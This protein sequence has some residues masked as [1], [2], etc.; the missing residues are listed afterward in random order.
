M[1]TPLVSILLPA[2]QSERYIGETIESAL[3]QTFTDWELVISEN[4]SKDK[5]L[6]VIKKY[7]D[8]RIRLFCQEKTTSSAMNWQFVFEHALGEF[9]CV[10]GADDVFEAN[11][12]E[13]KLSL[14][15]QFPNSPFVHGAVHCID[16]NGAKTKVYKQEVPLEEAPA[17]FL[18]R[19]FPANLVNA[20]SALFRLRDA[21]AKKIGFDTRYTLLM[22]WCF[23]MEFALNT[24]GTILYDDL[25]TMKYRMH[26]QNTTSQQ[27]KGFVW[28][29]ESIELRL[30]LL[31]R[32]ADRW[33]E[34]GTDPEMEK[35]RIT[36]NLWALAFQQVRRG[37]W[38]GGARAWKDYREYHSVRA[39]FCDA[40]FHFWKRLQAKI[41]FPAI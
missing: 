19:V 14:L 32:Y 5:T 21:K 27:I 4:A 6:E 25:V 28:A 10:L 37:C 9:G 33:R 40:P 31:N 30:N 1:S 26:S 36:K 23:W 35:T 41:N 11:H 13:R 18:A 29:I 20:H 38:G 8:P 39:M 16:E 34:M 7:S 2:Y 24:D 12:L 3:A 15:N 22:D 17:T